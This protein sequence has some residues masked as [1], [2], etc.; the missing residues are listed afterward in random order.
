MKTVITALGQSLDSTF[1]LRFGRATAFCI[2]DDE[3]KEIS[4]VENE[5]VHANG[6]AGTKTAQKMIELGI[7]KVVSG[8]F[9]PKAKSLFKEFN[10]QMIVLPDNQNTIQEIINKM[11]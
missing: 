7:A 9:G 5:Q 11:K 4:F 8:D 10:I 1:D 3:T 6:G 2:Y